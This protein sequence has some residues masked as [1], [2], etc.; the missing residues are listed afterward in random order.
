MRRRGLLAVVRLG[1]ALG[2]PR[3]ICFGSRWKMPLGVLGFRM[4]IIVSLLAVGKGSNPTLGQGKLVFGD[5]HVDK[6][7]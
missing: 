5:S 3:I 4:R 2:H 7:K 6:Y 1:P